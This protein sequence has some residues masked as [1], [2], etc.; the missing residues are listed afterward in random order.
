MQ[1][2]TSNLADEFCFCEA[3]RI[4]FRSIYIIKS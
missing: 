3:R 4:R 1:S 2:E